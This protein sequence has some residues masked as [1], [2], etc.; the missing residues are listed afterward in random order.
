VVDDA[1]DE[2]NEVTTLA[3]S[4]LQNV[5]AGQTTRTLTINDNDAPPQIDFA[6]ASTTVDEGVGSTTIEV[7][8]S[9]PSG[10]D[11]TFSLTT[12]GAAAVGTDFTLPTQPITIPAGQASLNVT[13]TVTNDNNDE[14]DE[15]AQLAFTG[16][17]NATSGSQTTHT[18]TIL[19]NDNPPQVRFD[20]SKGDQ[21][22]D[23]GNNGTQ[24]FAYTV[25][26]SAASG[27]TV[28]VGITRSGTASTPGDFSF[29]A[30]DIPVTFAPGETTKD[31][32]VVVKG[33]NSNEADETVIMTLQMPSNGTNAGNNQTRTH[34]IKNDD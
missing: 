20:P 22:V 2:D 25:V 33:D 19:D 31:V 6:Q 1:L 3:L 23:E 15:S 32:H 26:L 16:I 24:T 12:S 27:K 5:S 17:G 30:G 13:V 4:N 7:D 8:L 18:L 11:V 34:T 10:K 28:S 14:D 29:G 21:T 9:A